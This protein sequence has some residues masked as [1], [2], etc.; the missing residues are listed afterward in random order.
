MMKINLSLILIFVS[1]A[2]FAQ[3]GS[4]SPYSGG[5]LGE[6]NFNGTE[7]NR[8]MGGLDVFTDSIHANLN[9][10]ASFGLLKL[11][12]YSVGV[13]YSNNNLSSSTDSYNAD[14]ASLDYLAVSIPAG[15]FGFSFG[16]MPYSSLGYK[17]ESLSGLEG[18]ETLN[19]Y[20]SSGG[21]NQTYLSVGI[22]LTKFFA[23]GATANYNFG[24][25]LYRTGQFLNGVDNGTFLSN[26]SSISGL[27][28]LISAQA[29]IPIKNKYELQGMFSFQPKAILSSQNNSAFFSQSLSNQ[30]IADFVEID[31]NA[32]GLEDTF[33]N[34]SETQRIGLGIGEK[35]KWFI[36]AQRNL[37]KS[38]TFSNDFFKRE[39]I[40][41][42][43][44]KRWAVGGFYIPN[45]ASFTSF[46]SRVVYRFGFRSEQLSL[47]V[48]N[49]PLTET[50]IS[51]GVGLPLGGLSNANVGLEISQ[52]GQEE[53]GLIKETLI[54]L[55]I[56]LSL[57]D[58]WFIKRKYN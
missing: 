23:V 29:N 34:V 52:R 9:N 7:A 4:T 56:G 26:Q 3:N 1:S 20:E 58:R 44:A 36:G 5:G 12:T 30:S 57:S 8:H 19:R 49:I 54:A 45:Y 41:Y 32:Q 28:Y 16:I 46:W 31:L 38:A 42:R 40:Q 18:S 48:N 47:I 55:R 15:I 14:T 13:N 37:T 10:P 24:T 53:S 6:K 39:N 50:G 43:D 2:I 35:K 21:V 33:I 51:F 11:T 27:S 17:V 22:P 25:L